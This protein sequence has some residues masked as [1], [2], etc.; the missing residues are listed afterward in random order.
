MMVLCTISLPEKT[1]QVT[2]FRRWQEHYCGIRP[3]SQLEAGIPAEI[4]Q[5]ATSMVACKIMH[6][7]VTFTE[8]LFL[9][10]FKIHFLTEE[11]HEAFL[12]DVSRSRAPSNY[13]I[14]R[15]HAI[16]CWL[17]TDSPPS[18]ALSGFRGAAKS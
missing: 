7:V 14:Y 5:T 9:K 16:Y 15:T 8:D 4:L 11:F 1:P 12:K 17:G 2:A 10:K 18:P 13:R 3:M 6:P